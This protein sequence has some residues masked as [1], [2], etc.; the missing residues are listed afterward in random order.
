MRQIEEDRR[1]STRASGTSRASR[2]QSF[3]LNAF[4][5]N[6][7]SMF[8]N[9]KEYA[10]RRDPELV[11]R[12]DRRQICATGIRRGDRGGQVGGLRAAAGAR[13]RA[14]RRLRH[15]GRGPRRRRPAELQNADREPGPQGQRRLPGA[16]R[17]CSSGL[18]GQRAAAA[19]RA[20]PARVHDAR[21]CS[22]R[23]SPTRWQVYEG[24]LYVNDF[25]LF[26]RTWQVIVQ[27][28][29]D[30]ATSRGRCRSLRRPQSRGAH[31]AARLAGQPCA[32]STGR[33]C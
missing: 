24:S 7:G 21:A 17:H 20:R 19:H 30:S 31:G 16:R 10:E 2:G 23:I 5:S 25:N 28:D 13:R 32:R 26:G 27:A 1:A 29:A 3:V 15:H 22:C 33:W 8:I 14:G 18:P 11:Q 12:R 4:G 6:F 9:L